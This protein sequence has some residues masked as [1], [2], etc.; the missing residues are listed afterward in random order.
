MEEGKAATC[1]AHERR[2]HNVLALALYPGL[3]RTEAVMEAA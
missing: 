2:E 1:M 3:V